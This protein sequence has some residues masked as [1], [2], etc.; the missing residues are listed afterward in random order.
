M[1][2]NLIPIL[3]VFLWIFIAVVGPDAVNSISLVEK[4][5]VAFLGGAG[6]HAQFLLACIYFYRKQQALERRIE[7]I[8]KKAT[9]A[10]VS[11]PKSEP[12]TEIFEEDA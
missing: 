8:N 4:A 7:L 6:A 3:I 2:N 11:K 10:T 1:N 5:D 9:R 12:L